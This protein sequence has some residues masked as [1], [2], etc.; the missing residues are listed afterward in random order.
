MESV[1]KRREIGGM[2]NRKEERKGNWRR[3][4]REE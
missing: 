2:R 3:R 1:G 4:G